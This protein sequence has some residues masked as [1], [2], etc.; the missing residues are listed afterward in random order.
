[1]RISTSMRW[2]VVAVSAAML[3]AVAAACSSE[4]IEVPGETVVVEKEVIK[5][6]EVP[7]ETV[8]QEVVKEVQ[9]PGETVVVKEEVV[10][11][12]MV[13]GETVVV[14][15]VIT[16]T[17]EVPGETVTVEVVKTVEVPGQTVVVEKVVTQTVEVPGETVVVEKEV[18]KEVMVPG[19]TVV[20]EKQVPVEVVVTKVVVKEVPAGYVTDPTNG[21]VVT[22]PG[23]G[24]T[25]TIA[26]QGTQAGVDTFS[27]GGAVLIINGVAEQ[28]GMMDW[29]VDR[30][31]YDF[32][33]FSQPLWIMKGM[34]AESWEMPDDKTF[35]FNIRQGVHWHDKAPMNGRE[36]TAEDIEY[37]YHRYLGL[38]SG[39]TEPGPSAG[40]LGGMPWESITAT[41]KW[42]VVFKLKEPHMWALQD[43][44]WNES[45]WMYPP[46]VIE[47][48]GGEITD[49]TTLVGTGPWMLTDWV[50]GSSFGWTKNPDYWGY[51]EKY[52]ENRLPYIDQMR[53]LVL[54]EESTRLAALRTGKL[55]F[56][57]ALG[58]TVITSVDVS[59]SLERTNPEIAQYTY[60]FRS[61]NS[62]VT[63]TAN[64][65]LNDLRVRKALQMALDLE[66]ASDIYYKGRASWKPRGILNIEGWRIPFEEWPEEVKKGYMYDTEG[67]EKLL[68]AAGYTRGADGIRFK[69]VLKHYEPADLG[70][71]EL[72]GAYWREI[73]VDLDIQVFPSAEFGEHLSAREYDFFW[74]ESGGTVVEDYQMSRYTW[75]EDF[76]FY[77]WN[78]GPHNDPEYN[79]IIEDM[80]AATTVEEYARFWTEADMHIIENH[81]MVWGPEAPR[82][83]AAQPWVKGWNGEVYLGRHQY[84]A[85]FARLWIDQALK[86]QMGH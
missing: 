31:I 13:P 75:K 25:F 68:D 24:G 55:D 33:I 3:L 27:Q 40:R 46:E 35:V 22:A 17:V 14:E 49:W 41:D 12:V 62:F 23:Y 81:W 26:N 83:Q 60:L 5:T 10:K 77:E 38:G 57:G 16:E 63:A 32:R 82:I 76:E 67:A 1:M 47:Q 66:T 86:K 78:A 52:P 34:L 53:S 73:G 8:I 70:Y 84:Y 71:S 7:G 39:F 6:V 36:L 45:T 74:M 21:K 54:P 30:D 51:D 18:V 43:I 4:T 42:T 64:P 61:D 11:E 59:E 85:M 37:N 50:E 28:L 15:K 48:Y 56:V 9:V 44:L 58:N 79:R 69:T 65:P 19:E 29:A 80:Q 20:V 72:V 2:L